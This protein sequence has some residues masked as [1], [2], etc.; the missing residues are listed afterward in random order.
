[1]Q[2]SFSEAIQIIQSDY[3]K[4]ELDK[5][6]NYELSEQY[7]SDRI[8]L[9]LKKHLT[10]TAPPPIIQ[11]QQITDVSLSQF[12]NIQ[13]LQFQTQLSDCNLADDTF[14]NSFLNQDFTSPS[15][16]TPLDNFF[17][18]NDA[19][20]TTLIQDP[21]TYSNVAQPIQFDQQ[22][23]QFVE[24]TPVNQADLAS[25]IA[26]SVTE[27]DFLNMNQNDLLN[28]SLSNV[29]EPPFQPIQSTTISNDLDLEMPNDDLVYVKSRAVADSGKS[30]ITISSIKKA[31]N[32]Q[33]KSLSVLDNN[34]LKLNPAKDS[35]IIKNAAI[36]TSTTST[37][38]SGGGVLLPWEVKSRNNKSSSNT[39]RSKL[40]N[41]E[42]TKKSTNT[43]T[44]NAKQPPVVL[45]KDL[46]KIN[47]K[48][49]LVSE[50]SADESGNE[51]GVGDGGGNGFKKALLS[52]SLNK[53]G[54]NL[55]S[56]LL[57]SSQSNLTTQNKN[58]TNSGVGSSSSSSRSS[59]GGG[60][61]NLVL[62]V[63]KKR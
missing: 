7:E 23:Q 4:L 40:A 16:T 27:T 32:Q 50:G 5:T 41:I 53:T 26:K 38:N 42:M 46:L 56:S 43:S 15:L 58:G 17:T 63:L 39:F 8:E 34:S 51:S 60:Y 25:K 30:S 45:S 10:T 62:S 18:Q 14:F 49:P 29:L 61:K 12:G 9:I 3:K 1:M 20:Q 21:F 35:S 13:S 48:R 28:T 55:V 44:P 36:S 33:N 59:G 6:K 22:Q 2:G 24:L 31:S 57:K 54:N 52:Q 19:D 47:N 37:S 11:Q